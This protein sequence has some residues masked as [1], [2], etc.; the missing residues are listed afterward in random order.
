L[1]LQETPSQQW[2]SNK[3]MMFSVWHAEIVEAG[4]D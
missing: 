2:Y 1:E 3:K 4:Q